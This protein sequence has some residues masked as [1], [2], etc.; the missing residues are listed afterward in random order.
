VRSAVEGPKRGTLLSFDYA[1]LPQRKRHPSCRSAQDD[2]FRAYHLSGAQY[3]FFVILSG[4]EHE[5]RSEVEGPKRATLL[6]FDYAREVYPERAQRV[7]G[8]RMTMSF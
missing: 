8:L 4:A 5:V 1:T 6:P 2:N 7:E 3:T